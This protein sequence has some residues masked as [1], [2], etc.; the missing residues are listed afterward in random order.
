MLL[1]DRLERMKVDFEHL[2]RDLT[3]PAVINNRE[4]YSLKMKQHSEI[5]EIVEKYEEY[6]ALEKRCRDAKH[7]LDT[8][9]DQEMIDMA[10]A[11]F[12]ECEARL[13]AMTLELE[14]MLIPKDKDYKK[15]AIMEIRAGT[16]GDEAGLFAGD[17]YK[18][19]SKWCENNKY[20]IEIMESSPTN[21]GG[22]KEIIF[23]VKGSDAYGKL[24]FESGTH[25]VQR[26]PTTETQ[27]RIHT[28]AATVAVLPEQEEVDFELKPDDLKIE[29][30]RASG[31]G[32]QHVNRTESAVRIVHL[33]TMLEVYCQ[34]QRS[35]IKNREMAMTIL[36]ARVKNKL[37]GDEKAKLDSNRKAQI[38]SGDRSE[39]IRTYNYPQNRV[40]DHR[41]GLTIYNL[42][43]V[44]QGNIDDFID[45]LEDDYNQ[46]QLAEK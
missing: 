39:K 22:F 37:E 12:I 17:L 15:N 8:E 20:K 18:M 30:C 6:M 46:K 28:S 4:M 24:R 35:Q 1:L 34:V 13:K 9:R 44:M 11:E 25:R 29:V 33:P 38:G 32:G 27:G 16:G 2:N 21:L 10:R 41:I 3:D 43:S 5:K 42:E 23:M 7:L 19:Y 26:V 36:R 31:A 14:Y 40:T 45:K